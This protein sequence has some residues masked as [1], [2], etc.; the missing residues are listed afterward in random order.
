MLSGCEAITAAA[1]AEDEDAVVWKGDPDLP[2]VAQGISLLGTPSGH[3]GFV[4]DQLGQV[5]DV[6]QSVAGAH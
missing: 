1:R 3:P 5:D 4:R 2:T 6:A